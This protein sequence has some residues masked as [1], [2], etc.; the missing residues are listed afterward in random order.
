[1]FI[2]AYGIIALGLW[3]IELKVPKAGLAM[4]QSEE[5]RNI[6]TIILAGTAGLYAMSRLWRFHPACNAGYAAWLK[7]TPWTAGKP[8]PLGPLHPVWQD[9]AIIAALTAIAYWHANVDPLWPLLAFGFVYLLGFTLLLMSTRQWA[10]SFALGLLWP[11]LLL[12]EN[13]EMIRLAIVTVIMLVVWHG[14]RRSLRAFPWP[15]I[16]KQRGTPTSIGQIEIKIDPFTASSASG[17]A[18]NLPI[19][20]AAGGNLGW[21]ARALSPKIKPPSVSHRTNLAVATVIGWWCY[22]IVL[23]TQMDPLP[24]LILVFAFLVAAF[25]LVIYCNGVVPP[26]NFLGRIRSGRLIVPGFDK[27]FLAPLAVVAVAVVGGIIIKRSGPWYPMA[28]ALVVAAVW[29]VLCGAGP[30]LSGWVLTGYHRLAP[31]RRGNSNRQVREV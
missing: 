25:R 27:I 10:S 23:S 31:P 18:H 17:Q 12:T 29:L 2:A 26:F 3:A 4:A 15:P 30:T 24:E 22:C 5:I 28:E 19:A 14:H 16:S 21:P 13:R 9:G 6:R 20:P 11:A 1:M 7:M 8:L